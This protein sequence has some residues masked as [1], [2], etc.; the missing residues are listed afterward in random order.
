[1]QIIKRRIKNESFSLQ[2][3]R[4]QCAY[5]HLQALNKFYTHRHKRT[6]EGNQRKSLVIENGNNRIDF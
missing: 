2:L 5:T 6:E 4:Y 3:R 1:M